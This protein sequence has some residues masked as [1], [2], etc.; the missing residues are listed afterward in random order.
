MTCMVAQNV[1]AYPA[2]ELMIQKMV[3]TYHVL[4]Y[5]NVRFGTF[6]VSVLFIFE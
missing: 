6:V 1:S 2:W 5:V 3:T 4:K